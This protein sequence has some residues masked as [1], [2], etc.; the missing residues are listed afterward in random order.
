MT[1]DWP[2]VYCSR[3]ETGPDVMTACKKLVPSSSKPVPV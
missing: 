1:I 3:T 2:H